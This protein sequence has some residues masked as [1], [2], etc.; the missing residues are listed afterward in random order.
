MLLPKP[1]ILNSQAKAHNQHHPAHIGKV[2]EIQGTEL[3][4]INK[5]N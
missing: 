2:G 3:Q 4:D 5:V 1:L